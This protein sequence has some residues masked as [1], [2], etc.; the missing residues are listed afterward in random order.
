VRTQAP[1]RDEPL[2]ELEQV[3]LRALAAADGAW[4]TIQDF[5]ERLHTPRLLVEQALSK[6]YSRGLLLDNYS[7]MGVAF[8]LNDDGRDLVIK[9][10]YVNPSPFN[11]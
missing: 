11:V 3:I 6:L 10:G 4:V 8:R 1:R 2:T 5:S 9:L 7:S